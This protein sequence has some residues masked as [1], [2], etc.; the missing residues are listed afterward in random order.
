MKRKI[1]PFHDK[2]RRRV[3]GQIRHTI[4]RHPE[5]FNLK[6]EQDKNVYISSL[7]KRIVGEIVADSMLA[8]M[9]AEVLPTCYQSSNEE[10]GATL[11]SS[12]EEGETKLPSSGKTLFKGI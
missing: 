5:W 8:P 11:F 1:S 9:S 6:N 10:S 7:T 2:W 4:G 12:V 3:G